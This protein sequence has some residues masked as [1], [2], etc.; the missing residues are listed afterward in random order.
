MMALFPIDD[1][2]LPRLSDVT[3]CRG[4]GVDV[5]ART[6]SAAAANPGADA[7]RPARGCKGIMERFAGAGGAC[8]AARG[9]IGGGS[10]MVGV[11]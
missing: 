10:T 11:Y 9:G 2:P 5:P 8:A 1:K 7:P 4:G 3:L 6:A